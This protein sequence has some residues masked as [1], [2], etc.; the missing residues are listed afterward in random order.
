MRNYCFAKRGELYCVYLFSGGDTRLDLEENRGPF[1]VHWFNPRNGGE[2]QTGSVKTVWG[3]SWARI[4]E[5]PSESTQDWV[6]L[7]R[8]IEPVFAADA[9]GNIVVEAEHFERQEKDDVRKWYA[10]EKSGALPEVEGAGEATKWVRSILSAGTSASGRQ[11]LRLLPDTRKTHDDPLI[12]GENFSSEP[13][14]LAVLNYRVEFPKAGRYYVWVRAFSTGTEDNGLHVGIN[15]SWPEH[16][17]RMQWCEGKH[18]WRWECAQRTKEKH[19]GVPMENLSG[20]RTPGRAHG[21][22]FDEGRRFRV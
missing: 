4:G 9:D 20:C 13:G 21:Q 12:H 7:I 5:P 16:G 3:P 22:L 17:Q 14:K 19:C 10:L 18:G 8:K 11:F 6:A 1:S 2:L 15:G